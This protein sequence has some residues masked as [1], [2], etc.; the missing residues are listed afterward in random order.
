M[1]S[2]AQLTSLFSLNG[3]TVIITGGAGIL[4]QHLAKTF[5]LA[6][7]SVAL[8][9]ISEKSAK[10]ADELSTS[11]GDTEGMIKGYTHR[12][13]ASVP[14]DDLVAQISDDLGP[15]NHLM[16]NAASKGS[17]LGSFL[18]GPDAFGEK[19]W[20]EVMDV[21]LSG[22]FFLSK[23]VAKAMH[24]HDG[25]KSMTFVSSIYGLVGPNP[26]LY[27]GSEYGGEIITTPPIYTASKAGIIGLVRYL[28]AYWGQNGIRVNALTPGGIYSGQNDTFAD[29]YG[30]RTPLGRM[31]RIEE[32][33]GPAVFLASP[34]A[35]YI[36]GTNLVVDGGFTIW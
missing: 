9:D 26:S 33:V 35:A 16:N 1:T 8:V 31:G 24:A 27:E 22:T 2:S 21:N 28:A 12:I 15:I 6:G 13:S 25:L 7:A 20:G 4:G 19:A 5:A 10:L 11:I 30:A 3:Q 34:A 18:K 29:K 17:D 32:I 23:S 14:S 36:T